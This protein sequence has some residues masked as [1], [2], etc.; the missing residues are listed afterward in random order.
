MLS[1]PQE[2]QQVSKAPHSQKLPSPSR[3]P[4]GVAVNLSLKLL[5]NMVKPGAVEKAMSSVV[6]RCNTPAAGARD[7][8][9]KAAQGGLCDI[10]ATEELGEQRDLRP[11]ETLGPLHIICKARHEGVEIPASLGEV[12]LSGS[13][14]Q[15]VTC[16]LRLRSCLAH[17][18]VAHIR[19]GQVLRSSFCCLIN[20]IILKEPYVA[21]RPLKSKLINV[22]L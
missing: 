17:G 1:C 7:K 6:S 14:S 13:L 8:M 2:L 16:N 22:A 11:R 15:V 18:D 10:M 4:L 21:R 20:E 9:P 19:R 3:V 12:P 5:L